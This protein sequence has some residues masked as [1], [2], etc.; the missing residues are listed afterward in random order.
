MHPHVNAAC[1]AHT[2]AGK[3]W[4][5]TG[6][7]L[8]MIDQD[9]CKFYGEAQALYVDYGGV[10]L[11]SAIGE[12]EAIAKALGSK[13]KGAIL[14]NH[15]LLTVG[16]TVDEAGYL[17]GLLDKSCRIQL[18][19][20]KGGFSPVTIGDREAEFNFRMESRSV[21]QNFYRIFP[22]TRWFAVRGS[23]TNSSHYTAEALP[24]YTVESILDH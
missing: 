19:L 17:F 2:A 21:S 11:G 18:D 3:A 9:V 12:G 5:A 23:A 7:R 22:Y 6:Q 8:A 20:A 14:A 16:E 24:W 13:G 4:S 10:V 1:H 15:G